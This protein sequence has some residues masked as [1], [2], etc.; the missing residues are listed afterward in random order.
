MKQLIKNFL[1][2]SGIHFYTDAS[3]P[4][5]IHWLHDV[6]RSGIVNVQPVL[7]DVGANVGQTVAEMRRAFPRGRIHAFEPFAAPRARLIESVRG[8]SAVTVVPKAMGSA[9]GQVQVR[10]HTDTQQSSLAV[11]AA[12]NDGV[13]LQNIEVGTVDDHCD[14]HGIGHIDVLKT[15]TEGYDLEVLRGASR[16]LAAGR[17]AF[18]LAEV[19]F[20]DSDRQHTSFDAVRSLLDG[21]GLRLVGLYE[22][23]PLHHFPDP[24]MFCNA[25]FVNG[26]LR[27]RAA[28]RL[29]G[30]AC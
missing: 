6:A 15:D 23:Y 14:A 30:E 19:G 9:P 16:R 22:T 27:D 4:T 13:Q 17:V 8:D 29:R 2:H 1:R 18:V 3:L 26:G 10:P 12:V 20:I 25:L 24:V 28:R 11:P 5:G 7:L 21:H